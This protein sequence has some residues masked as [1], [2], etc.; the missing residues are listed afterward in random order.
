MDRFSEYFDSARRHFGVALID[1]NYAAADLARCMQ[2]H[3]EDLEGQATIELLNRE[4]QR[5]RHLSD[6]IERVAKEA[7]PDT[8]T[9]ISVAQLWPHLTRQPERAPAPRG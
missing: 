2:G 5:L 4:I 7:E 6:L 8:Q 9:P 1:L 3:E